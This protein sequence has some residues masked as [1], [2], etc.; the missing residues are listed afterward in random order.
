MHSGHLLLDLLTIENSISYLNCTGSN[1]DM[2][3]K[4]RSNLQTT[5]VAVKRFHYTLL[6]KRPN[7]ILCIDNAKSHTFCVIFLYLF[8]LY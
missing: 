5:C 8:K 2:K 1:Q 6:L 3:R 4:K 7:M